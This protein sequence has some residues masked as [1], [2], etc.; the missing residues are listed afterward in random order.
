MDP[1]TGLMTLRRLGMLLTQYQCQPDLHPLPAPR[2][3][4]L[5]EA[6]THLRRHHLLS[7]TVPPLLAHLE[8]VRIILQCLR[9]S[10]KQGSLPLSCPQE[11][12]GTHIINLNRLALVSTANQSLPSG[13]PVDRH[14]KTGEL[15]ILAPPPLPR[16]PNLH[17]PME[18]S[19][20]SHPNPR[21]LHLVTRQCPLLP[22]VESPHNE[23]SSPSRALKLP[24][25]TLHVQ[26]DQGPSAAEIKLEALTERLEKEMDAQPKA[27]YF[28]KHNV[29]TASV[30]FYLSFSHLQ[31]CLAACWLKN[32][33]PVS[34][35]PSLYMCVC[36]C[37]CVS[38]WF[39]PQ[40]AVHSIVCEC[41][42][43]W[44]RSLL[45]VHFQAFSF[46][47]AI[48]GPAVF[49]ICCTFLLFHYISVTCKGRLPVTLFSFFYRVRLI[50]GSMFKLMEISH[51]KKCF[52]PVAC[53]L[54]CMKLPY[55]NVAIPIIIRSV[56]SG[57]AKLIYIH[58]HLSLHNTYQFSL[59]GDITKLNTQGILLSFMLSVKF[60]LFTLVTSLL[61]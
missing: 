42:N 60:S 22:P 57:P 17:C 29:I 54:Q 14:I 2:A 43:E 61:T 48:P 27:E 25:Q 35:W 16:W 1:A 44:Y 19:K 46:P 4:G 23:S 12:T 55:A 26:T 15:I 53:C 52:L 10:L 21:A 56:G 45:P 34:T 58:S 50:C 36:V 30:F 32:P 11:H 24:C 13:L 7:Q 39:L 38:V 49:L 6:F 40:W 47:E 20:V 18:G 37:M 5:Q 33:L 9:D 3:H 51:T 28:G 59:A 31:L 8:R 41:A